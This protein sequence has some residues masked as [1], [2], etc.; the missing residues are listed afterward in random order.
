MPI[1]GCHEIDGIRILK[2][3]RGA[4]YEN[5]E[6][7]LAHTKKAPPIARPIMAVKLPDNMREEAVNAS[8]SYFEYLQMY[9]RIKLLYPDDVGNP[10]GWMNALRNF[11]AH[12]IEDAEGLPDAQLP[13]L[14][15]K[16]LK[17]YIRK[18]IDFEHEYNKATSVPGFLIYCRDIYMLLGLIV[19][20]WYDGN[21]PHAFTELVAGSPKISKTVKEHIQL[22]EM[23]KQVRHSQRLAKDFEALKDQ[24]FFGSL[25]NSEDGQALDRLLREFLAQS[26]HRGHSD[27]DIYFPRYADDAGLLYRALQAH[28]KSTIDDPMVRHREINR[29]RD[30][31]RAE[32]EANIRSKP[33]GFLQAEAFKWCLAYVLRFQECRDDSRAFIDRN[34]YSIRKAFL[35]VNR[36][37]IERGLVKTDR[38]FW[39]LTK[40][41]LYELLDGHANRKL[42]RSKIQSRM[43]NFDAFDR[44]EHKPPKF[45]YRNREIPE[46]EAISSGEIVDGTTHSTRITDQPGHCDWYG[47]L[48]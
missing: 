42:A 15:D 23:G 33:F 6:V 1:L 22:H 5:V 39:F 48:G 12:R 36:R 47:T 19:D 34:T 37:L 3:Y 41:E 30:E 24:A 35:E 10:Y 40:E 11:E 29:R 46:A 13:L 27:R 28:V 8:F 18:Q 26:R 20:K 7:G 25:N 21:N 14:A 38:D 16:E 2:Y 45:L 31:V 32:V 44:K 17:R 9:M 4:I 43:R